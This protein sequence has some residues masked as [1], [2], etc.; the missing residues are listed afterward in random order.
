MKYENEAL[1][2]VRAIANAKAGK[3]LT[4]EEFARSAESVPNALHNGQPILE[5]LAAKIEECVDQKGMPLEAL[6]KKLKGELIP[7]IAFEQNVKDF[8]S[9]LV[10]HG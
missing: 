10:R 5:A 4:D 6:M 1:E 3:E 8:I 9:K 7:R 2:I